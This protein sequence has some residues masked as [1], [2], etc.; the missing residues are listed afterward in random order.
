MV[1]ISTNIIATSSYYADV[2]GTSFLNAFETLPMNGKKDELT[3][4]DSLIGGTQQNI[5]LLWSRT[6]YHGAKESTIKCAVI[7]RSV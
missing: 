7:I 5:S 4:E 2:S 1:K 6:L 3:T